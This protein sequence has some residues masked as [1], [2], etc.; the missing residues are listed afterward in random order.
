MHD[1]MRGKGLRSME[2]HTSDAIALLCMQA[3]HWCKLYISSIPSEFKDLPELF[4]GLQNLTSLKRL[5]CVKP[6][7]VWKFRAFTTAANLHWLDLGE[8]VHPGTTSSLFP[9]GQIL[10]PIL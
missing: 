10:H 3:H 4:I 1:N 6:F 8:Y 2:D 7:D 5:T 9:Y